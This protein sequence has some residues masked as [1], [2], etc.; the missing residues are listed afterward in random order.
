[1]NND[2]GFAGIVDEIDKREAPAP[3]EEVVANE[4]T[5][6][7]KGTIDITPKK[8]PTPPPTPTPEV[9]TEAVVVVDKSVVVKYA[10][11]TTKFEEWRDKVA[12]LVVT[13]V[14]HTGEMKEANAARLAIRRLRLDAK[15][16]FE[17]IK[18]DSKKRTSEAKKG[19]E[20]L[21]N[22]CKPLE[23]I[24]QE[25]EDF[26]KVSEAKAAKEKEEL[27]EKRRKQ[28]YDA[29]L[30]YDGSENF[31]YSDVIINWIKA[32]NSTEEDFNEILQ[33]AITRIDKLKAVAIKAAELLKEEE[34]KEVVVPSPVNILAKQVGES[35]FKSIDANALS[36]QVGEA[37]SET[38][39]TSKEAVNNFTDNIAIEKFDGFGSGSSGKVILSTPDLKSRKQV[40]AKY[41]E[42]T[43]EKLI[44]AVVGATKDKFSIEDQYQYYLNKIKLDE[45]Q[46]N[47]DQKTLLRQTFFAACGQILSLMDDVTVLP[48][49]EQMQKID[50]MLNQVSNHF[51]GVNTGSGK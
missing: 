17:D 51:N 25:K 9:K 21:E 4:T 40:Y 10:D 33:G 20:T 18:L 41:W 3:V 42:P 23:I 36:K 24:L 47:P 26:K 5:Q 31:I 8:E 44:D 11:I 22:L 19:Y 34:A 2:N 37:V 48:E 29:G 39:V 6:K 49:M 45:S 7:T 43:P 35:A 14:S 1:M 12:N 46:M 28:L 16:V 50:S 38:M 32:I 13:D 30:M 15:D 27:A